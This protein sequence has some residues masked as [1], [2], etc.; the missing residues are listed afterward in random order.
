VCARARASA[1]PPRTPGRAASKPRPSASTI[2]RAAGPKAAH[3]PSI[4]AT[5]AVFHA[6]MFALNADADR[7][8]CAPKP[9]AVHAGQ[10]RARTVSGFGF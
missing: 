4:V 2:V 9:H 3:T 5:R 8:A 10:A 6:P 7:N 1:V